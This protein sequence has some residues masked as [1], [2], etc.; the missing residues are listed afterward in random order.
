MFSIFL[1]RR[2]YVTS[3]TLC[4]EIAN[5]VVYTIPSFYNTT[6]ELVVKVFKIRIDGTKP[7]LIPDNQITQHRIFL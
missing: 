6:L 3:M 2:G 5:Y 1:K 4:N 7:Q